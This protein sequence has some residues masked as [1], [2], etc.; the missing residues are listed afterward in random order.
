MLAGQV[1]ERRQRRA[2]TQLAG[3]DELRHLEDT[4]RPARLRVDPGAGG[5]GRAEVDADDEAG[6]RHARYVIST[7]A[8]AMTRGPCSAT[9]A[10]G[11]VVTVRGGGAGAGTRGSAARSSRARRNGPPTSHAVQAMHSGCA[12]TR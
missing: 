5:V 8:G 11:T 1:D 6:R 4:D 2:G 10:A 12:A 7:S 3:R 9:S